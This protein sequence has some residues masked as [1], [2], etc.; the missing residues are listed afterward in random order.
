[1]KLDKL[2][3]AMMR[4]GLATGGAVLFTDDQA[5]AWCIF[6]CESGC[7]T[8]RESC[9]DGCIQSGLNCGGAAHDISIPPIIVPA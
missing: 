8:C 1:M 9:A 5:Y 6:S 3:D 2:K 4:A 7:T